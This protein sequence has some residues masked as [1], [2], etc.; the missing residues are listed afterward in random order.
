MV[1]RRDLATNIL[2]IESTACGNCKYFNFRDVSYLL[3]KENFEEVVNIKLL[4]TAHLMEQSVNG[5]YVYIH[6]FG[7]EKL[8]LAL[9]QF[10]ANNLY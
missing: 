8:R 9:A 1:L 10:C 3:K 2:L 4:P 5:T 6:R 7:E